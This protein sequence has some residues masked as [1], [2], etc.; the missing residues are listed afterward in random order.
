GI[1][2]T[3][4]I[5]S[6]GGASSRAPIIAL[7]AH[8]LADEI[9]RFRA[10]GM[11]HTLTK[12]ISRRMLQSALDFARGARGAFASSAPSAGNAT[13]GALDLARLDAMAQD[14]GEDRAAALIAA[15]LDEAGMAVADIA[16]V[17]DRSPEDLLSR[18]HALAGSAAVFGA[19]DLHH[20]LSDAET[21][22][23]SGQIDQLRA[24][25]PAIADIWRDTR[26]A[27]LR[28]QGDDRTG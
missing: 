9:T 25:L 19:R 5:R 15:F 14:V 1:A 10:A 3:Q 27:F 24:S 21:K 7:T 12:P 17:A 20:W 28:H 23:K 6:E 22:G 11:D 4:R 13:S 18:I 2:A 16:A 26:A 8:A